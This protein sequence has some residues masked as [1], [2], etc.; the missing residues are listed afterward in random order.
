MLRNWDIFGRDHFDLSKLNYRNDQDKSEVYLPWF[1]ILS[2][3][4]PFHRHAYVNGSKS[5]S[6]KKITYPGN[7]SSKREI[8]QDAEGGVG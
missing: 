7:E 1:L 8:E 4:Q 6:R 5:A 3:A 2:H